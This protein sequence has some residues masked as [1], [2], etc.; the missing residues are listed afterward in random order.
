MVIDNFPDNRLCRIKPNLAP[1]KRTR[2]NVKCI[3][4]GKIDENG[5]RGKNEKYNRK[6]RCSRGL[7]SLVMRW[8]CSQLI[9]C[10]KSV[11]SFFH[12]I[13]CNAFYRLMCCA[14]NKPSA[15]NHA[16][17]LFSSVNSVM[18]AHLESNLRSKGSVAKITK[19]GEISSLIK[20]NVFMR[21]LIRKV[22][23]FPLNIIW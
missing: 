12:L 13:N 7:I 16:R 20:M 6:M 9:W 18:K 15:D 4:E 10:E 21:G 5:I 3:R 17:I 19:I 23:P 22:S 2:T 14:S 1:I 8:E 11:T